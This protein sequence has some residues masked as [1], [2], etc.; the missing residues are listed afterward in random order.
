MRLEWSFQI[1]KNKWESAC[2][3]TL[4][5][6]GMSDDEDGAS[7]IAFCICIAAEDLHQC[8]VRCVA[9]AARDRMAQLAM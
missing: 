1:E 6:R 4:R 3:G 9:H 8:A 7:D 5:L 2:P